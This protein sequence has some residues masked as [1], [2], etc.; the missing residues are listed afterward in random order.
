M[1][2]PDLHPHQ[3]PTAMPAGA[4]LVHGRFGPFAQARQGGIALV[5]V[6]L[7]LAVA[8]GL[9]LITARMTLMGD[10]AS[11]NDRDRQIAFQAAELALNDAELLEAIGRR[12]GAVLPGG[13]INVQKAAEIVLNEFRSGALGR[14]SLETPEELAEWT[15]AA[16]AAEA[17]REKERGTRRQ[18][19]CAV[20]FDDEA[21]AGG[22]DDPGAA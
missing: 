2:T 7:M 11:R 1:K 20:Q 14:V 12:R 13:R 17:E 8:M 5:F 10:K 9:A 15:A 19:G 22:G 4:R 6:L 3:R 21:P 16:V 18:R